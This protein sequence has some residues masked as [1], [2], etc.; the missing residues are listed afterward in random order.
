MRGMAQS[1]YGSRRMRFLPAISMA[2]LGKEAQGEP[3]GS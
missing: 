2:E 1:M 3:M